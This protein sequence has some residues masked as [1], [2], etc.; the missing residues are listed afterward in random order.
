[1]ICF[2]LGLGDT[3]FWAANSANNWSKWVYKKISTALNYH[4]C[5]L[6]CRHDDEVCDFAVFHQRCYLGRFNYV[7]S[8][9]VNSGAYTTVYMNLGK[10]KH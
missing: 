8:A 10:L 3:H 2:L 6:L 9:V 5:L 4:H 7:G 1:M